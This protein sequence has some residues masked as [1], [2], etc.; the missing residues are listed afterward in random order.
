MLL[1][2][3]ACGPAS[4][5]ATGALPS[6]E[7]LLHLQATIRHDGLGTQGLDLQAWVGSAD[8]A[9]PPDPSP[10]DCIR[11]PT[12]PR[13]EALSQPPVVTIG[14]PYTLAWDEAAGRYGLPGAPRGPDPAWLEGDLTGSQKVAGALRFG[15]APEVETVERRPDGGLRLRWKADGAG[16]VQVASGDLRCGA[17]RDGVDLPWWAVPAF[18][19]EVILRSSVL[20]RSP[21]ASALVVGEAVIERI[22]YL[23]RPAVEPPSIGPRVPTL[24]PSRPAFKSRRLPTG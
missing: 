9:R 15:A 5:E 12:R 23:D 13:G 19:G 1:L 21:T 16:H 22:V 6:P 2:L 17:A 14:E 8:V 4:S 3:L 20:T 10:G 11:L 7:K 18:G 24:R